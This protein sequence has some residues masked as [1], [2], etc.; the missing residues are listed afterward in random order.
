MAQ[1]NSA[2]LLETQVLPSEDEHSMEILAGL[3]AEQKYINPKFFYDKKGSEL[4]EEI[5]QAPEYYPTRT[6]IGILKQNAKSIAACL[7]A[8]VQLIEPG[9]GSCEKVRYL[10]EAL[11][12][13]RYLPMDISMD[14]LQESADQLLKEHPW[15]S[16]QAIAADF[17]H[18]I[19][20]P[21]FPEGSKKVVFYPGST[22]GNFEPSKAVE[23]LQRLGQW[24]K[25]RGGILM[26][27]DLQKDNDVLNSAY[28]DAKGITEKFNLNIL[29]NINTLIDSD[30]DTDNFS[31]QAFYNKE[32]H[33]IE[34]HLQAITSHK[35]NCES[36]L[37]N[38]SQGETIHTENSYKYTLEG[39]KDLANQAGLA[40][41]KSWCDDD[42]LFSIN[43]LVNKP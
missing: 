11:R 42:K 14:F 2:A 39:I 6:E 26:G 30:F 24:T 34:M 38:F 23:F 29:N 33:R 40:L 8:N 20:F 31:H 21:D 10:L 17:N 35:V 16:V 32:E 22:I 18:D 15:L 43:Y 36:E 4:F 19:E 41:K 28:N 5:T 7:G 1:S 9:A 3:N 12:P 27:V 13:Q 25:P 37:I